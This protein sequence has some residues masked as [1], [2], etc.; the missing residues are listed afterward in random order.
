VLTRLLSFVTVKSPEF[1]LLLMASAVP[2]SFATWM[3]LLDN[4]AVHSANF[5]GREI[6]ILQSLREV[7]GFLAFLI[8]YVLLVIRE[9][10]LAILS[11]LL[12]GVGTAI[13]GFFP[14]ATGLY[15]CT[16]LMSIGFHYYETL[17]TSLTLQWIEKERTAETLGRIIAVGSFSGLIAYA[18]VYVTS[19]QFNLSLTWIYL[20]AGAATISIALIAWRLF[21]MY[22][23]RVTQHKHIVLRQRYWL[24][25]ALT[26][27]SGARRQ[28]FIVFAGFLMVEKFGFDVSD[29]ALLFLANALLNIFLAPRIGR[30]VGRIGERS[31]LL[32]EYTGL[33]FIFTAYAFVDSASVA[34]GLYILDHLFFAMA[35]AIKTYFQK[36]ADERDIA[37]TAGVSFTINHIAAVFLPVVLG[38]IWLTSPAAVFLA[39]AGMALIS[40]LLSCLIPKNPTPGNEVITT[41]TNLPRLTRLTRSASSQSGNS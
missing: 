36:I 28:I 29:I 8:I 3:A 38:L 15:I 13:T 30:L 10:R 9:Q 23:Q 39:G 5:T 19:K 31:A 25:Y 14:Y 11:L 18:L 40:L 27:M 7:P 2:L 37:S 24:Y 41:I 4:F 26:F 35:I 22:P 34:A 6:G 21:P 1:L 33:I 16:V 17:Q 12:L 32:L 20:A